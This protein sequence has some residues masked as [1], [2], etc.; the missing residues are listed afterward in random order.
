[1]LL[2][3]KVTIPGVLIEAGFMTNFDQA[4]LMLEDLNK[5]DKTKAKTIHKKLLKNNLKEDF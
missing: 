3:R 1:M 5:L 2:N 4:K